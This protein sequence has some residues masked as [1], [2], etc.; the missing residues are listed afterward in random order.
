MK[1]LLE[2]QQYNVSLALVINKLVIE[3]CQT[4]RSLLESSPQ[5]LLLDTRA[6]S[7]SNKMLG[8][9]EIAQ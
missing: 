5:S 6:F 3:L 9:S 8:T 1:L 4:V 7:L 2:T